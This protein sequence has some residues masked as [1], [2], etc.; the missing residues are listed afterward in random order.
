MLIAT[1]LFSLMKVCVKTLSHIPAVEL[2]FFRS[3]FS[4]FWCLTSLKLQGVPVFGKP[5]NRLNLI[6][7]GTTG[8]IALFTFFIVIQRI[9]LATMTVIQYSNP[10]FASLLGVLILREKILARQLLYFGISFAG[11]FVIY[12]FDFRVTT[13]DLFLGLFASL[14]A[15]MAYNFI[16]KVK[17]SEHPLVIVF[18]FPLVTLPVSALLTYTDW[19]TPQGN[20][21]YVILLLVFCVQFAQ[22]FMTKSYQLERIS[23]VS[24]V[25]Y[26]GI[27]YAISF[28]Y[29]LF[30]EAVYWSTV[31]GIVLVLSGL[32]LNLFASSSKKN[33][34]M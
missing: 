1:L 30:E 18:Y 23:K 29:F 5:E 21:W 22:Y 15:G 16:R 13:W 26:S 9:P 24:I 32:V 28:G 31:F 8:A 17:T 34:V 10:I 6:L 7:R 14:F 4:F 11:I 12:G 3:V 33:D 19:V 27:I 2:V 20:D 25:N